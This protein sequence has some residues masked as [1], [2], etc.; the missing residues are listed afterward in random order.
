MSISGTETKSATHSNVDA[1][2]GYAHQRHSQHAIDPAAVP[3]ILDAAK[4]LWVASL[5]ISIYQED[6]IL[7]DKAVD[8]IYLALSGTKCPPLP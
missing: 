3:A 8:L 7:Q 4:T 1:Q 6:E 2:R 5:N